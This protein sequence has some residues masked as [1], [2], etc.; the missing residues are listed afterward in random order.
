MSYIDVEM[1][2]RVRK[3]EVN[4]AALKVILKQSKTM[5]NRAIAEKLGKPETL[6]AHWFRTDKYFAI[7]DADIWHELKSLIGISTDEFDR[8]ITEF[9][10]TGGT[11]DMRNRIFYGDVAPTLTAECG[12][13]LYLI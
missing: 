5:S 12:M 11:F 10:E 6:V 4:T 13:G 1:E 7:P 2:V 9:E 8:Q 3:H